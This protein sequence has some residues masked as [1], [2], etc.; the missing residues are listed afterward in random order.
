MDGKIPEKLA[1]YRVFVDGKMSEAAIVDVDL[2]EI[3]FMS[4]NITG[5]GIL[6]EI[7]SVTT[8]HTSA[9]TLTLNIRTLKDEDFT[10]LEPRAYNLELKAGIQ[11]Y[12][13]TAGKIE[14]GKY[15][16]LVKGF[17]KGVTLGKAAVGKPTDSKREFTVN[18]IKIELDGKEVLEI[19]KFNMICKINGTDFLADLRAAIGM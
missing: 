2:P 18:Y 1:N 19:D 13:R 6:G 7:E 14:T 16:V 9:L 5:A 17:P 10:V 11:S 12:N 8:G 4:E 15:N 3:K